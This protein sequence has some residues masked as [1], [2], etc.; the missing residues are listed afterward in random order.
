MRYQDIPNDILL[1]L[2]RATKRQ[3]GIRIVD[4]VNA[5]LEPDLVVGESDYKHTTLLLTGRDREGVTKMWWEW[6]IPNSDEAG[7]LALLRFSAES[8]LAQA[9]EYKAW[10][11]RAMAE[12]ESGR[13]M[14]PS[15]R[16]KW[17]SHRN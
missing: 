10:H 6:S 15:P 13:P 8:T 2:H 14:P 3:L 12:F 11:D 5:G 9:Y 16:G 1:S 7:S 17:D 4:C